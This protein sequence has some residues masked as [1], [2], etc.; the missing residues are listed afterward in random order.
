MKYISVRE[1]DR[2]KD[3]KIAKLTAKLN[4]NQADTDYI[5]MMTGVDIDD[6]T[7]EPV[8]EKQNIFAN[9]FTRNGGKQ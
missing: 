8:K 4:K 2:R 5:A 9:L 1:Q 6:T 3:E 7:E